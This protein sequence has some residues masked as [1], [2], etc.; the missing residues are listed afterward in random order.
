VVIL[1]GTDPHWN[2]A[3]ED[4]FLDQRRKN[5]R[6]GRDLM[7]WRNSASV[8]VGRNQNPFVECDLSMLRA[9][10]IPIVR[11]QSGGGTV[12]H[13]L[14]NTNITLFANDHQPE[15]NLQFVIR[16]LL[17]KFSVTAHIS[18]RKD[19]FVGDRKASGSAYRITGNQCYH[20]MTLLRE[21]DL[22]MLQQALQSPLRAR[23]NDSLHLEVCLAPRPTTPR[24][25]IPAE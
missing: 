8:I 13:D 18:P 5:G 14:G 17:N 19:I 9:Q 15:P 22:D 25:A 4:Y 20:H 6:K 7:L 3:Y 21:S 1:H 12:Y 16:A 23:T 10:G 2:L 24:R 11:R